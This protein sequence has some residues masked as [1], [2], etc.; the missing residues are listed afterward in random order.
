MKFN[1]VLTDD[2]GRKEE[3]VISAPSRDDVVKK[4]NDRGKIILA[5]NEVKAKSFMDY[6][7]PKPA[8]NNEERLLFVKN[9]A[10]MVKVGVT[11]VEAL[12]IM[13]GQYKKTVVKALY[14]DLIDMINAG[15]TLGVALQKYDYV[16]SKLFINMVAM[17]EKS[18]NLENVLEYLDEQL[19][20]EYDLKKKIVSAFIY[21]AV[22]I[23]ITLIMGVG[24]VVF[25][26]PKITAVFDNFV[27]KVHPK[28]RVNRFECKA[29]KPH[30]RQ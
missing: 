19:E 24:I 1:Y 21:P 3:G 5:V 16:F 30:N 22:I 12:E 18:G 11:V 6:F 7:Q 2:S 28:R 26:M 15:Q 8:L 25:I 27:Q 9:M 4:L 20:K 23:G 14:Q 10:T 13:M 17:G 29:I